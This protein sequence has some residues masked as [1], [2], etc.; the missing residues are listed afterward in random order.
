MKT[1]SKRDERPRGA[2]IEALLTAI[3]EDGLVRS[4]PPAPTSQDWP[5]AR[6]T[7]NVK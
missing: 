2:R 6:W 1:L 3:P 5:S 7:S 4:Y